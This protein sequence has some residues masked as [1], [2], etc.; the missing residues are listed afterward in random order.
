MLKFFVFNL[1]I[2]IAIS[3][4][5]AICAEEARLRDGTYEG[6]HSFV[7]VAVTVENG[8]V[9]DIKM[10]RHGGGGKKY[11]TMVEPLIGD[12]IR[13]QAVDVDSVTGAT[14][15]SECLKKAVNDALQKASRADDNRE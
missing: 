15:S 12:M 13:E 11:A 10:V 4:C 2:A 1:V 8:K 7:T 9:A 3:S 6:E 14:V 5:N